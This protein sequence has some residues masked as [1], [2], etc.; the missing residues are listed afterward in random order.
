MLLEIMVKSSVI[1]EDYGY[2]CRLV[3]NMIAQ[4]MVN[5]LLVKNEKASKIIKNLWYVPIYY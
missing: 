2:I 4:S 1:Y 5:R 3:K